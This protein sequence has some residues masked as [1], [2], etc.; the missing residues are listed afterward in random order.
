MTTPDVEKVQPHDDETERLTTQLLPADAV[1]SSEARLTTRDFCHERTAGPYSPD[2][3]NLLRLLEGATATVLKPKALEDALATWPFGTDSL[4]A[5][6]KGICG[7]TAF[8]LWR[9]H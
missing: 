4:I 9:T 8:A 7:L 5:L 6:V 1:A 2:I 3:Y